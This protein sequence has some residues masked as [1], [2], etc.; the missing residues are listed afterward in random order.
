MRVSHALFAD[1]AVKRVG[2]LD[3]LAGLA[4]LAGWAGWACWACWAGLAGLVIFLAD[5]WRNNENNRLTHSLKLVGQSKI[6][7]KTNNRL[8]HS[9]KQVG[10][11]K[12]SNKNN[13]CLFGLGWAWLGLAPVGH[14]FN[15]VLLF[16]M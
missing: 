2:L 11:S 8:T 9:L 4:G 10:Q 15:F 12:I 16:R 13:C 6:S 1:L 14:R 5:A 7:N 3:G